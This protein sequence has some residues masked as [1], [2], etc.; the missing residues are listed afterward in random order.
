MTASDDGTDPLTG[1]NAWRVNYDRLGAFA[2][3]GVKE[4]NLK[5]EDLATTTP[6]I[7]EGSFPFRFFAALK[8]RL[9]AWFADAANGIEQIVARVFNGERV[10]TQELCVDDVCVTRDEFAE[11]FGYSQ[12]AAAAGATTAGDDAGA[13]G[14]CPR[15]GERTRTLPRLPH[16]AEAR[17]R[18]KPQLRLRRHRI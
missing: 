4:L 17:H 9:L 11:V 8:D 18:V 7:A 14:G 16:Q 6:E 3:Q 13:P 1:I 12:S 2:L 10:E 15:R 5:L